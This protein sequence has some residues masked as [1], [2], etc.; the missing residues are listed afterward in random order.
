MKKSFKVMLSLIFLVHHLVLMLPAVKAEFKIEDKTSNLHVTLLSLIFIMICLA[1]V[2]AWRKLIH[3]NG[4]Q[5]YHPQDLW[6]R[7]QDMIEE[8]IS[9]FGHDTE[10][11][12]TERENQDEEEVDKE[13]E[14]R[15][16]EDRHVT[17]L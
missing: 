3:M 12:I 11:S 13:D 16:D 14:E 4:G 6:V 2:I 5:K 9:H 7:T 8:M 17:A 10:G 15:G 1:F